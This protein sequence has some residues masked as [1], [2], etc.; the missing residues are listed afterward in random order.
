MYLEQALE[1][2]GQNNVLSPLLVLEILS[3]TKEKK[4]KQA[5]SQ[6]DNIG[7]KKS[8]SFEPKEKINVLRFKVVKKFLMGKLKTQVESIDKNNEKVEEH[9]K[10][11]NSMKAEIIRMKQTARTFDKKTCDYCDKELTLPTIHFLCSH[12]YHDHCVDNEGVRRCTQCAP[13]K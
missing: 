12:S 9:M 7:V 6:D 11:I 4:S 5:N 13:G 8:K 2:I 3:D 10:N 1:F